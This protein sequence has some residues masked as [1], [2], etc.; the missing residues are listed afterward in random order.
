MNSGAETQ[1]HFRLEAGIGTLTLNRPLA[2]N[3]ISEAMF[4]TLLETLEQCAALDSLR[5]LVLRA[6][7]P[8]FCAG[9]DVQF[10][11]QLL[12]VS[13]AE[14][15]QLLANYIGLAHQVILALANVPCPVVASIR[16]AAAGYGMSL[17]CTADIIVAESG[18]LLV[19]AYGALGTTPDGGMTH[20]LPALIGEKRTLEI[21]LLNRPVEV[22]NA[23]AWGLINRVC[24]T[25]TLDDTVEKIAGRIASGSQGVASRLKG[26]VRSGQV[27]VLAGQLEKELASFLSCAAEPDFEE[28]VHAFLE[29]REPAFVRRP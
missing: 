18:C 28:G 22:E 9:G 21:L 17:A 4:R 20:L 13:V 5:A 10:F 7:G 12:T 6:E 3:S 27:E 24:Q 19:P 11:Q 26:L 14:R 25:G 2:R 15:L 16:G 1:I 23:L 8:V 29:K